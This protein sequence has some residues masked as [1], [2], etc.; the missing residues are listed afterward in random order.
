MMA[1]ESTQDIDRSNEA[2]V[3]TETE[4]TIKID[5]DSAQNADP[6]QAHVNGD[7]ASTATGDEV[8]NK[9]ISDIVDDLVNSAEVSISG[10]SDTEASRSSKLKDDDKQHG[11][12]S[13]TVRKP[14]SFK[15]VSVN[16]TFLAA[17]G[18]TSNTPAKTGD[19]SPVISGL[20]PASGSSSTFTARP[21]LV[22]KTGSG[23]VAK[24]ALNGDKR[25]APDPNAVW[26]KNRRQY[27]FAGSLPSSACAFRWL[28]WI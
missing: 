9:A 21:R 10:G 24:S 11:R 22:A 15:A 13:S 4:P 8:D 28:T 7:A 12:T 2:T 20:A 18:A 1:S 19:K 27:T 17:K 23:L 14:I 6:D 3:T 26:N 5:S 25:S 16:K